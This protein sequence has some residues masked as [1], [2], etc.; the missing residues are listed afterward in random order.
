MLL[1]SSDK[2]A[3]SPHPR[4]ARRSFLTFDQGPAQ[5]LP[6]P[7]ATHQAQRRRG[8]CITPEAR[9]LIVFFPPD[10]YNLRFPAPRGYRPTR[11]SLIRSV[12]AREQAPRLSS[13]RCSRLC[14]SAS[15]RSCCGGWGAASATSP[16]SPSVQRPAKRILCPS[17]GSAPNRLP[18]EEDILSR[19]RVSFGP[20]RCPTMLDAQHDRARFVY[21]PRRFSDLARCVLG[22]PQGVADQGESV[23]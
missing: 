19:A 22:H 18:N 2:R 20:V 10:S 23:P 12:F 1:S 15:T 16:F 3:C 11:R 13:L 6:F 5:T 17:P 8:R 4:R 14:R 7:A 21:T 9:N